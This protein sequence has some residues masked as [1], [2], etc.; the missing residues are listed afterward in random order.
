MTRS[1]GRRRLPIMGEPAKL[2][3]YEEALAM[4]QVPVK[5]NAHT[6]QIQFR[7]QGDWG[8]CC[9]GKH[10]V[11]AVQKSKETGYTPKP[12]EGAIF[13]DL[14][15]SYWCG[16]RWLVGLSEHRKFAEGNRK[17]AA[18]GK[19]KLKEPDDWSGPICFLKWWDRTWCAKYWPE[20]NKESWW[21][22]A[23]GG[24]SEEG[25][26]NSPTGGSWFSNA[27]AQR[28]ET[29]EQP[30]GAPQQIPPRGKGKVGKGGK[31]KGRGKYLALSGGGQPKGGK[32]YSQRG[33]N[34]EHWKGGGARQGRQSEETMEER[35]QRSE[36]EQARYN[37]EDNQQEKGH[38]PPE[39]ARKQSTK[40]ETCRHFFRGKCNKGDYC[41]FSHPG[42]FRSPRGGKPRYNEWGKPLWYEPEWQPK[43]VPGHKPGMTHFWAW[44]YKAQEYEVGFINLSHVPDSIRSIDIDIATAEGYKQPHPKL[45][46][47]AFQMDDERYNS[48]PRQL[49]NVAF[50]AREALLAEGPQPT[51]PPAEEEEQ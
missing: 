24:Q 19:V 41:R 13:S 17:L 7:T 33:P 34:G 9:A 39:G 27:R 46:E 3:L 5:I 47:I 18:K 29:G 35:Q 32:E 8:K 43:G 50:K 10:C 25:E 1:P 22:D 36:E 21:S 6:G 44:N 45:P 49:L 42:S 48:I 11:L 2:P 23:H 16:A 28:A 30:T 31:N 14:E 51:E 15:E 26:Q 20:A 12:V 4:A 38:T 40:E 37:K